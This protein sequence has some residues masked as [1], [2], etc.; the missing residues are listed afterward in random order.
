MKKGGWFFHAPGKGRKRK[1]QIRKKDY[2]PPA[3]QAK[4]TAGE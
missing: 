3:T 2:L 4:E 1:K